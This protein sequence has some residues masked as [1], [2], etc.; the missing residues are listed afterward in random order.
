MSYKDDGSREPLLMES[1]GLSKPPAR[2]GALAVAA[3]VALV[4]SATALAAFALLASEPEGHRPHR[5]K[6]VG[7]VSA[8]SKACA[9]IGA[10]VLSDGGNA[11]DAAVAVAACLGVVASYHSG[12]GG[13]G[14]M[15]VRAPHGQSKSFIFR[16]AAPST[17]DRD[18]FEK[19][20]IE[21]Q[22]GGKSTAVPGELAGLYLAHSV[23]GRLPWADLIMPA[24]NI[25]KNGFALTPQ[26]ARLLDW[27]RDEVLESDVAK[28]F[29]PNGTM[30]REGEMVYRPEYGRTLERVAKEGP[31]AFYRSDL[32]EKMVEY[33]NQHGG[34]HKLED[35]R[36][37]QPEIR[38]SISTTYRGKY[39]IST[40]PP[41]ASGAVLLSILSI[42]DELPP[43]SK[44]RAH[45]TQRLVEAFKWSY[46][47]RGELGDPGWAPG[48][49]FLPN[50]SKVIEEATDRERARKIREKM[51]DNRT[52]EIDFYAPKF[53]PNEIHGTTHFSIV[54]GQGW[55][56]SMTSTIN[57][58][59]G[60]RLVE[61]TTGVIFNNHMDDFSWP[62]YVNNGSQTGLPPSHANF[63]APHKRPVSASA[64]AIVE[65]LD[66]K[67]KP[68]DVIMAVGAAGGSKITSTVAQVL[69][70]VLDRKLPVERAL[71]FPR[72]H[73]QLFPNELW[74]EHE[75]PAEIEERMRAAG[76][77]IVKVDSLA[78]ASAV[79]KR[80]QEF[81]GAG[82][83][84]NL[85]SGF[86]RAG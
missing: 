21:S 24:A 39:R 40:V 53:E 86:A 83:W 36:E 69:V 32:T 78:V 61:P 23:F 4:A 6:G 49:K 75:V 15:I 63:I 31:D 67:G 71:G 8:E 47:F 1:G 20:P 77:K 12:I 84:R 76:H 11:V 10:G 62:G 74:M 72:L 41:P 56:V 17:A 18:M 79:S 13:G 73:H 37:Y 7:A 30:L 51:M 58:W 2:R 59:W 60:N 22:V 85:D 38:D 44:D 42:L 57:L 68:V 34:Q 9:E 14:F 55:A 28:I 29:A 25:S 64:P 54:D 16:E 82:D 19:N 43:P 26:H 52:H 27:Y 80:D 70:D 45:Y 81:Y 5:R 66:K 35:W 48:F 33:L 3:R 65:L 46:A 50:I